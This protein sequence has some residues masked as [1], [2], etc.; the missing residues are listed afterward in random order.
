MRFT[1]LL[2]AQVIDLNAPMIAKPKMD[3]FA[4]KC[5]LLGYIAKVDGG[6]LVE[7]PKAF[8]NTGIIKIAKEFGPYFTTKSL[9]Q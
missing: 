4:K 2:K 3:N 7:V 5:I 1:G 9:S 6:H 8:E